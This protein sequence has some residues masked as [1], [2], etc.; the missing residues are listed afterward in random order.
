MKKIKSHTNLYFFSFILIFISNKLVAQLNIINSKSPTQLVTD[1]LIGPGVNVSNITFKGDKMNGI[2]E[3]NYKNIS[4]SN[5]L[6]LDKGIFLSTGNTQNAAGVNISQN[7]GSQGSN[8]SDKDLDSIIKKTGKKTTDATII[9]F[10]FVPMSDSIQFK[11]VFASEEYPEFNCSVFNDVFAFLLTGPDPLGGPDLNNKNLAIVPGTTNTS[12]SVNTINSGTVSGSNSESICDAIDAN[13]R[14]YSKYF[15]PN[16]PNLPASDQITFDGYTTPLIAKSA[17]KCGMTYHMKI[18]VADVGDQNFD[19][20]VFLLA[21]SLFSNIITTES[22]EQKNDLTIISDSN[23]VE[24]C[25][26]GI[27]TFKLGSKS[28]NSTTISYTLGG[29]ATNGV[30]FQNL[31]GSINVPANQDSVQLFITPIADNLN[32]NE[33]ELTISYN[34]GGCAGIITKK[35]II[36]DKPLLPITD[37]YYDSVICL[38]SSDQF[39]N[40]VNGFIKG[41]VFSSNSADLNLNSITG[42]ISPSLSKPGKYEVSYKVNPSNSCEMAGQSKIEIEIKAIQDPITTFTYPSPICQSNSTIPPNLVLDFTKGGYFY[43]KTNLDIDSTNGNINLGKSEPGKHKVYYHF[44]K[45]EC[46]ND[47][48]DSTEIEILA[49]PSPIPGFNYP[50]PICVFDANPI[51]NLSTGFINGGVFKSDSTNLNFKNNL[52]GEIDLNKT[53]VGT[54]NIYYELKNSQNC[55]VTTNTVLVTIIDKSTPKI[56]FSYPTLI[57][58]GNSN[59]LP[60]LSSGFTKGG[61]FTSSSENLKVDSITGEL[62]LKISKT[63]SYLV[64]YKLPLT[65]CN[66]SLDTSVSIKVDSLISK[67]TTFSYNSPICISGTNP[68]PNGNF[69]LGGTFTAP[70]GVTIS[71]TN[72]RINLS[73]TL[74]GTY[75]IVYTIDANGCYSK[76]VGKSTITIE[77]SNSPVVNF[78]YERPICLNSL[79]TLPIL[80]SDFTKGGKFKTLETEISVNDSTGQLDLSKAVGGKTYKIEYLI[81]SSAC[82]GT[83]TGNTEILIADLRKPETEFNYLDS[84]YC[85]NTPKLKPNFGINFENGGKFSSN[86][87]E[88]KIDSISGEID[89]TSSKPGHFLVI[90]KTDE[91]SCVASDST[92]KTVT[93]S[94]LPIVTLSTNNPICIGDTLKLKSPSYKNAIYQWIGPNNF[95]STDS[96][97]IISKLTNNQKGIYKLVINKNNCIDSSIIDVNINDIEKIFITPVGP[98]CKSDTNQYKIQASKKNGIW[99]DSTLFIDKKDSSIIYFRPSSTLKDT[100]NLSYTTKTGCGGLGELKIINNSLPITDFDISSKEG[101]APVNVKLLIPEFNNLDSCHWFIDGQKMNINKDSIIK[102]SNLGVFNVKVISFKNGCTSYLQKDTI[103][104][105]YPYPTANFEANDTVLSMFTPRVELINKSENATKYKW[106]FSDNTTSTYTNTTHTFPIETNDYFITLYASQKGFCEDSKTLHITI[107]TD[108]TVYI[109]NTFTPNND[110]LNEEFLPIISNAID[111][112]SYTLTIFNRWGEIIFISHDKSIGWIGTYGGMLC[113]DGVYTWKVE[114]IDNTQMKKHNYIGHVTL[115]K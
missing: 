100:L 49:N 104:K 20:G 70:Q 103:L 39:V 56:T 4:G 47:K 96:M 109:P 42:K 55:V 76:S 37:F 84:L 92:I 6:G 17:V 113:V 106:Y 46:Y 75:E 13:W 38:N 31:S 91:K 111:P 87:N 45:N 110:K 16:Y 105:I 30:D 59:I 2:A 108:L 74:P 1:I 98:F 27:L 22:R 50:S 51:P 65:N 85:V 5:N 69:D 7:L 82:G 115:I 48:I 44:T 53:P 107:P 10:D 24:N 11:Y 95:K 77:G 8:L 32:E 9:E 112:T 57:C 93:I 43:S 79:N 83:G 60:T 33:E 25:T 89:F 114:F 23:I 40:R 61:K 12:V 35:F 63:G 36:R 28:Q 73:G 80:P 88:L 54:Y 29:Q 90:Y 97:P 3:F 18:A 72:G 94:S 52:T 62:N 19:S 21:N 41:G 14:L 99:S 66:L 102:F 58:I 15:I 81:L 68:L 78:S 67:N 64:K 71:K 101:C 86:N 26:K 34:A